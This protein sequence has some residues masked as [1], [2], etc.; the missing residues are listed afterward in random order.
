MEAN[1]FKDAAHLEA[2]NEAEVIRM[3]AL[4][5]LA[6]AKDKCKA[7]I[8]ESASESNQQGNMANSRKHDQKMKLNN[9]LE[10]LAQKGNMVVS[11]QNGQQILSYFN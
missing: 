6:V 7:L 3:N 8:T 9:G 4:A 11:G 2:D 1:A 10:K 5:R